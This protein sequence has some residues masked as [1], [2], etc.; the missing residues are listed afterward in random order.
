MKQTTEGGVGDVCGESMPRDKQR[1]GAIQGHMLHVIR[2]TR[3]ER[4]NDTSR[5]I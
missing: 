3:D 4:T 2:A 1:G 5:K